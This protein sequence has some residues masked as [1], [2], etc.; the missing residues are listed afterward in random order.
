MKIK[1]I[2][3]GACF[4]ARASFAEVDKSVVCSGLTK[5]GKKVE[6]KQPYDSYSGLVAQDEKF[7]FTID[8]K[9][10]ERLSY[11]NATQAYLSP[12]RELFAFSL[13]NDGIETVINVEYLGKNNKANRFQVGKYLLTS[14]AYSG[15]LAELKNIVCKK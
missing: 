5:D 8:G 11:E 12:D 9:R 15:A 4:I 3:L 1:S 2:I 6:L 10:P 7:I 14:E 13:I